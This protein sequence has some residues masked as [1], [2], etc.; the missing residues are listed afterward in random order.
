[1]ELDRSDIGDRFIA[2]VNDAVE[3]AMAMPDAGAPK[4]IENP[5]IVGLRTWLI[6]GFDLFRVYYLVRGDNLLLVRVLHGM[7]D[8]GSILKDQSVDESEID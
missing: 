1:L 5:Q 2:A 7:R 4:H 8:I 3:G 6:A